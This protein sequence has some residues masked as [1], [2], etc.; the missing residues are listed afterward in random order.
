MKLRKFQEV[1]IANAVRSDI[2]I[3]ALSLPRG[4]GKSALAGHLGARIITPTD[5]LFAL[6]L[7]RSS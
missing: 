7:N 2:N 1:F 4:N 6:E 3:A 5:R